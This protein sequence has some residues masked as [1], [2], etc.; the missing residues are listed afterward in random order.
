MTTMTSRCSLAH[1]HA[2]GIVMSLRSQL[3]TVGY[4]KAAMTPRIPAT[5][6]LAPEPAAAS[7]TKT[8][9]LQDRCD[10]RRKAAAPPPRRR[11]PTPPTSPP[12]K[13]IQ[14]DSDTAS[15]SG[16]EELPPA[17]LVVSSPQPRRGGI[18]HIGGIGE[19]PRPV[20]KAPTGS[21]SPAREA[22]RG[23]PREEEQ[24]AEEKPPA[25]GDITGA[26]RS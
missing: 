8:G 5:R 21:P 23:R 10:R 24:Q 2:G 26:G 11:T 4:T 13:H 14:D 1:Q 22:A 25:R 9:R 15:D 17:S 18:G 7:K 12:R 19:K 6:K 20:A 3:R 16:G